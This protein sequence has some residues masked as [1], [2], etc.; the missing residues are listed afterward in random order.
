MVTLK[1]VKKARYSMSLRAYV[2][3]V[4]GTIFIMNGPNHLQKL[5][6]KSRVAMFFTSE[7]STKT[8]NSPILS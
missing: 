2:Y 8:Y 1:N 6:R 3:V 7:T 5:G 4:A